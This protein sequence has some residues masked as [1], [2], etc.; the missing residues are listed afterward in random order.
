MA[1]DL[2]YSRSRI[3]EILQELEAAGYMKSEARGRGASRCVVW[4]IGVRKP[5]KTRAEEGNRPVQE[6]TVA[7]K[8]PHRPV[9]ADDCPVQEQT[10]RP[11]QERTHLSYNSNL[12]KISA[13]IADAPGGR[14]APVAP[15]SEASQGGDGAGAWTESM[16]KRNAALKRSLDK[17][18]PEPE[19]AEGDDL[20]PTEPEP[21]GADG[22]G[23]GLER[24]S[25]VRALGGG[26]R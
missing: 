18:R 6:R 21:V 2:G 26:W 14:A 11:V 13:P 15:E 17:L 10:H 3:H 22:N 8:A 19:P 12:Q 16:A 9:Q 23:D 25:R 1:K 4:P 5:G 20:P 24:V 7:E